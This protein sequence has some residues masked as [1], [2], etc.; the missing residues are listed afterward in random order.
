MRF[1]YTKLNELQKTVEA[2][3]Q[4]NKA[5]EAVKVCWECVLFLFF[6]YLVSN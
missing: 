3:R 6:S 5:A 2:K 4:D 1:S